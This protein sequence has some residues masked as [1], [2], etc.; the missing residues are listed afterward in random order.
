MANSDHVWTLKHPD[1]ASNPSSH[2]YF[3]YAITNSLAILQHRQQLVHQ[4]YSVLTQIPPPQSKT[5]LNTS[6]SRTDTTEPAQDPSSSPTKQMAPVR[7][8]WRAQSTFC[9]SWADKRAAVQ[10]QHSLVT[11][12][13]QIFSLQIALQQFYGWPYALLRM[14][15]TVFLTLCRVLHQKKQLWAVLCHDICPIQIEVSCQVNVSIITCL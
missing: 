11:G 10:L 12:T 6:R 8:W 9:K 3:P 14:S 15:R 2:A 4:L 5:V 7:A 13:K 1:P